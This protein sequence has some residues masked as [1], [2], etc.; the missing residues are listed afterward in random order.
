MNSRQFILCVASIAIGLV[1]LV[2]WSRV[3]PAA[4]VAPELKTAAHL[5]PAQ[6][7]PLE[8]SAVPST[9]V[10]A[11]PQHVPLI[12]EVVATE[13]MYMAHVPLRN[14]E[15]A[16]PDSENNRRILQTMVVKALNQDSARSSP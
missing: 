5:P 13:R 11:P 4:P 1:A 3:K 15:V 6:A 2:Y 12:N 8:L 10:V 14:P 16:D 7:K 9:T